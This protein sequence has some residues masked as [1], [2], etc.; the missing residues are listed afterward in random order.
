MYPLLFFPSVLLPVIR[1]EQK[2]IG[3][4][5][6]R[7]E[8]SIE[9][10]KRMLAFCSTSGPLF[11]LGA[12]GAGMLASPAAGAVI[13]VSHYLGA[14]VNGVLFRILYQMKTQYRKEK[15]SGHG[16][17]HSEG[18]IIS[19]NKRSGSTDGLLDIF[20]DSILSSFRTLGVIC[21]YIV[22]FTLITDF[23]Q[24]S[25]FY[26]IFG[27]S[28][29]KGLA[30]GFFEMTVGCSSIAETAN[31]SLLVQCV[32]CTAII[33]WGGL[34]ILAQSMSMLAGLRISV[35][36][37]AAVKLFHGILAGIIALLIGPFVLNL[38]VI[39]VGSFGQRELVDRLG[40]F[41][42]L[43]FSTKMVIMVAIVF[44]V[45]LAAE[46]LLRRIHERRRDH[47]GI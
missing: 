11:M 31:L 36:Y 37:Y 25:G 16:S 47:R 41:Y 9:D 6:R 2:L 39:S 7:R 4:M 22:L 38:G 15:R 3:D 19:S 32:L 18:R 20:T 17:F 12:V 28:F 26:R 40:G 45:T 30:K 24:F 27:A 29:G 14:I 44:A 43:L 10:A 34:S 1:W 33:S 5:G 46:Q 8:V 42:H 13:A 35:W 23:M 21:G